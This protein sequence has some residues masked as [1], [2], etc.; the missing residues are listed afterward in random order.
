MDHLNN[1]SW[2]FD[3]VIRLRVW[4]RD[5]SE[6]L[7]ML[8]EP[9]IRVQLIVCMSHDGR[10]GYPAG[11][12]ANPMP[13]EVPPLGIREA[14]LSWIVQAY[15]DDAIT[16]LHASPSCFSEDDCEWVMK[17]GATSLSEIEKATLRI[18]A[19]NMTGSVHRAARTLR[20][21]YVSLSRWFHRREAAPYLAMDRNP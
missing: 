4:G 2:L 17:H 5:L 16:E 20:M 15:A 9:D 1:S 21:A 10:G 14:E 7:G 12:P 3:K 19:V 8:D 11:F 6:F 13:I 18:V